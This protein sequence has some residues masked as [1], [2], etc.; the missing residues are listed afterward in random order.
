MRRTTTSNAKED[1]ELRGLDLRMMS[2]TIMLSL[3]FICRAIMDTLNAWSIIKSN[4]SP[5]T[6]L[7]LII[8]TEVT[9]CLSISYL[10]KK[11][12]SSTSANSSSLC[13][14][15]RPL[16]TDEDSYGKNE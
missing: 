13:W 12:R 10:M 6:E 11:K 8:C 1:P 3:L 16:I 2:I 4:E 14:D 5:Y 7:I 15:K 9:P